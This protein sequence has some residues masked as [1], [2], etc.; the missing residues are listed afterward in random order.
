MPKPHQRPVLARYHACAPAALGTAMQRQRHALG[1]T[2]QAMAQALQMPRGTYAGYESGRD[3]PPLG[4]LR[5]I[6]QVCGVRL[7]ALMG[8]AGEERTH[9]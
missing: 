3:K 8:E 5:A 7:E 2:Q 9:A 1:L 4:L 6:A